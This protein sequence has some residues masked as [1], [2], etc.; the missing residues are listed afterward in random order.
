MVADDLLARVHAEGAPLIDD[1]RVTFVWQGEEAPILVGEFNSWGWA[2]TDM[3]VRSAYAVM[4]RVAPGVWAYTLTLPRDAYIE[5]AYLRDSADE[6]RVRDPLNPRVIWNGVDADNHYFTMPDYRPTPLTE[7]RADAPHGEVTEHVIE[8]EHLITSGARTVHLYRPPVEEPVPLVVVFDGQDYLNRAML[9]TI[10]DNLIAERRIRPI[11]LA[12]VEHG[13]QA[14]V[15]EYACNE[16]TVAFVARRVVPLARERL[17]LVDPAGQPGGVGAYGVLGASM[18]GL[19]SLYTAL[20]LPRIF[21][22]VLSQSGAF[23]W[24]E[25]ELVPMIVDY[26]QQRRETGL[27]IWMDVGRFEFLADS[28]RRMRDA[29][30]S[31]GYHVT[32]QE[33]SGGHNYTCWRDEVAM[34]LQTLFG[35]SG[36]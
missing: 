27:N 1:D 9:P 23:S 24:G 19:I 34:G 2:P 33:Y 35:T 21:G 11:A 3:G 15:V 7:T 25:P 18:G 10:V 5:Y 4:E 30:T 16:A 31:A 20:R 12:M 32:Y 17:H 6:S 26:A 22:H 36:E 13:D 29:L 8:D 14:R 28:N